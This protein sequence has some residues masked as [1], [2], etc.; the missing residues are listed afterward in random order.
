[1]GNCL[2]KHVVWTIQSLQLIFRPPAVWMRHILWSGKMSMVI[3]ASAWYSFSMSN[4]EKHLGLLRVLDDLE[5]YSRSSN[6][7]AAL[8]AVR[9]CRTSLDKLVTRMDG[10]ESAFDRIAERSRESIEFVQHLC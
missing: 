7:T 10:L 2:L 3:I 1:M 4:L 5:Q 9:E 6:D 8:S